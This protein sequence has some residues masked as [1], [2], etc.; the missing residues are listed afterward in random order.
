MA[1]EG[2]DVFDRLD[3]YRTKTGWYMDQR[4]SGEW[5]CAPVASLVGRTVNIGTKDGLVYDSVKVA[6]FD[7]RSGVL[8]L[9]GGSTGSRWNDDDPVEMTGPDQVSVYDV[10]R[11]YVHRER[12]E[13]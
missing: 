9:E 5:G 6:A 11:G 4:T 10:A 7:E 12:A 13:P 2:K 1:D 3:W 8:T